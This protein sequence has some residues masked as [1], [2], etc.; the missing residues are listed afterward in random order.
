[1]S[2]T[3]LIDVLEQWSD[4]DEA[5]FRE[6]V[7]DILAEAIGIVD[8]CSRESGGRHEADPRAHDRRAADRAYG[9][10]SARHV[11][12]QRHYEDF[13]ARASKKDATTVDIRHVDGDPGGAWLAENDPAR[14]P[15]GA[16]ELLRADLAAGDLTIEQAR[17]AFAS[18]AGRP[19]QERVLLRMRVAAQLLPM[20]EGDWVRHDHMAAALGIPPQTLSDLMIAAERLELP[21]NPEWLPSMRG[22]S[23]APGLARSLSTPPED[24]RPFTLRGGNRPGYDEE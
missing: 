3:E 18:K 19:T 24:G 16:A 1:M 9:E 21:P 5:E 8:E 2:T 13:T 12:V 11:H 20:W 15:E 17:G 4:E 10:G 6:D 7:A 14:T 23:H 22:P